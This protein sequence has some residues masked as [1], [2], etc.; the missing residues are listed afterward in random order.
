MRT[1]RAGQSPLNCLKENQQRFLWLLSACTFNRPSLANWSLCWIDLLYDY[2]HPSTLLLPPMHL[3]EALN[4]FANWNGYLEER[5]SQFR[6]NFE[7]FNLEDMVYQEQDLCDHLL[8]AL[9]LHDEFWEKCQCHCFR[10]LVLTWTLVCFLGKY[11]LY[12]L[13]SNL[14]KIC[15]NE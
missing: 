14:L 9:P 12:W 1:L 8:F 11:D 5:V 15:R 3:Q 6:G 7:P 10:K 2:V 4:Y 13:S